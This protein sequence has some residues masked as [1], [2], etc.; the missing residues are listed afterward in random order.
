MT[1]RIKVPAKTLQVDEA[2]F[3]SGLEHAL[4]RLQDYRRPLFVGAGVLVLAAGIVGGV[5]WYDRQASHKAEELQ[6]GATRMLMNRP[7]SDTQKS[8]AL[9]KQA[10]AQYRQVVD[11]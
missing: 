5:F 8:D 6:Q 7:A 10:I 9:L 3:V 4:V 11:L 1:Y 2:H